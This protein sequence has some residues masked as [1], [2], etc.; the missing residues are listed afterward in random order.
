MSIWAFTKVLS[1]WYE[2][3]MLK[4]WELENWK[5]FDDLVFAQALYDFITQQWPFAPK[6]ETQW[7]VNTF[8]NTLT[9]IT[10]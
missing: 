5:I 2:T 1:E 6:D 3:P 10:Q 7:V 4:R 9:R 8:W